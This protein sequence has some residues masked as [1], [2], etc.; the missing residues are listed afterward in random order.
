MKLASALPGLVSGNLPGRLS[1]MFTGLVERVGEVIGIQ[2]RSDGARLQIGRPA[3]WDDVLLGESI[4][5]NGC[6]LTVA[7]FGEGGLMFDL[8]RETLDRTNLGGVAAGGLVNL[9]RSLAVGARMG[10]H[11][12]QGHIDGTGEVTRVEGAGDDTGL[13]FAISDQGAR[14]LVEK[15]SIAV[16][17]VSLTVADLGVVEFSVW[18]IPHTKR[19]T[20][21]GELR[22]GDRVNLEFD[23]LAKYTER[24]LAPHCG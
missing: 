2:E 15:G 13:S 10:G 16:N 17:G 11:F 8:L 21:L 7:G 4:A 3:G 18:I 9:E 6:C 22:V 20:N 24:L 23:L 1:S 5:V 14:Y 19:E 12:V